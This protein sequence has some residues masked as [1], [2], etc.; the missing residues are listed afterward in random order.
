[1]VCR[2]SQST[3]CPCLLCVCSSKQ[4]SK[5]SGARESELEPWKGLTVGSTPTKN[6]QFDLQGWTGLGWGILVCFR[7]AS[8]LSCP[9]LCSP[10]VTPPC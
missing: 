3:M 9:L 8:C 7:P 10:P 6:S 2:G 5:Q 4:A 1:M